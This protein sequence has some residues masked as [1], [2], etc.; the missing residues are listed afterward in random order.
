[1][2]DKSLMKLLIAE[3]KIPH[4]NSCLSNPY[5]FFFSLGM[6]SAQPPCLLEGFGGGYK[7][8]LMQPIENYLLSEGVGL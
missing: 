8:K 5:P 3:F 1:M 6:S 7:T 4:N 2:R